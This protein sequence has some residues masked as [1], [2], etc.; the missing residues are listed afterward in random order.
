MQPIIGQQ[1]NSWLD[2]LRAKA[3]EVARSALEA[4]AATYRDRDVAEVADELVEQTADKMLRCPG[5]LS[6]LPGSLVSAKK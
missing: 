6:H 4:Y 2:A 1:S 5:Y 3:Q